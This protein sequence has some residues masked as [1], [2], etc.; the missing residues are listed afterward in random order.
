MTVPDRPHVVIVGAGFGGLHA[1][2]ALKRA[3]VRVTVVDRH[4]Y[5]LFQPLLYQVATATLSPSNIAYPI[6]AILKRQANTRVILADAV[7]VNMFGRQVQFRDG[8]ISYDYV[9]LAVGATHSYFGHP[10]WEAQAPGLKSIEDALEIRRRIL[11]AFEKAERETDEAK[12]RALLT[13]VIVGG[14]P[15]GVELA[16]AIAEMACKEMVR[17]FRTID[18]RDTHTILVEA[19]PRI[20]PSFAEELSAKAEASL[21]RLC[22][23]VRKNSPVTSI[24]QG[25]IVI[26]QQRLEA[27]TVLWAAGTAA[28]PLARSLKTPLD[29]AGR[30]LVAPDLSVPGHPDIF[31][32]GDLAA[33]LHQTGKPL[34]GLAPVAVQQ[35]RHAAQNVLRLCQGLSTVP[36]RYRERGTLATIGRAAAVAQFGSL[37]LSGALAWIIWSSVHIFVLIGF[38]NRVRVFLEWVWAYVTRQRSARLITGHHE[39]S[40]EP[41]PKKTGDSGSER[42]SA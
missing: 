32:I 3:A 22:V 39:R 17:D 33:F 7:A 18:P 42:G 21:T 25:L 12:R 29:S 9:I 31:V 40:G 27:A 2:R 11:L 13:F 34:P 23:E 35:G 1:A 14:G 26:G 37:K 41:R 4:N 10:E 8:E 36:F 20:L 16:G 19:G 28:S 5:H 6:R 24:Q 15:T 38:R 30:V